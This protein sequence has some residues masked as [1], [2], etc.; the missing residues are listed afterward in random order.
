MRTTTVRI[1]AVQP[2]L[3]HVVPSSLTFDETSWHQEQFFNITAGETL[4]GCGAASR[5]E[6]GGPVDA[7]AVQT[8]VLHDGWVPST[9]SP[10]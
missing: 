5:D 2:W 8:P 7:R 3:V 6:Q 10:Q 4:P 9:S 1:A